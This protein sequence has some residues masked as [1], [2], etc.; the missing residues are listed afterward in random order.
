MNH[1]DTLGIPRTASPDEIKKAFRRIALESHPDKNPGNKQAENR[2]K[3]ANDA[4]DTL[5]DQQKREQYDLS[6]QSRGSFRN[7]QFGRQQGHEYPFADF[8]QA[9]YEHMHYPVNKDTIIKYAV[10]LREALEGKTVELKYSTSTRTHK[11]VRVNIPRS[12]TEGAKIRFTSMGDDSVPNVTPGDLYVIITILPDPTFIRAADGSIHM[13][14]TIDFIDAMVGTNRRITCLDGT[15]IDLR[16]PAGLAPG[17]SIRVPEKGFYRS[18]GG[19]V[20]SRAPMYVEIQMEQPKLSSAQ[21]ELL[22][23]LKTQSA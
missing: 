18:F 14:M 1:Y 8:R 6:L 19:T 12:I 17:A 10:T 2:F 23:K 20:E 22:A 11:S 15:E 7:S 3:Q 21:Y 16:I 4:Y 9:M 13:S 5:K